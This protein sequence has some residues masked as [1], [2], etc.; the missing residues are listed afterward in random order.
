M[1][2]IVP[3]ATTAVGVLSPFKGHIAS[4][5][6]RARALV[7]GGNIKELASEL[8][9]LSDELEQA[10]GELEE[11]E[12]RLAEVMSANDHNAEVLKAFIEWSQ[13]SWIRRMFSRPRLSPD[14]YVRR[15]PELPRP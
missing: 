12:K 8:A 5:R 13:S 7:V 9:S 4:I 3:A 6:D 2:G 1:A 11:M 15:S 14:L 10:F